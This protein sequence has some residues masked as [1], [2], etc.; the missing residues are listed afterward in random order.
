MKDILNTAQD[1]SDQTPLYIM[2]THYQDF[3]TLPYILRKF[4][5]QN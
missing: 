5:G 3:I 2:I 4:K 1:Q